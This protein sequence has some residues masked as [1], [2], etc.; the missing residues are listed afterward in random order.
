MKT[1]LSSA[2]Y[3]AYEDAFNVLNERLFDGKLPPT[4]LTLRAKKNT[5]GYAWSKRFIDHDQAY[6]DSQELIPD[7]DSLPGA[8]DEIAINPAT[9]SRSARDVLGTLLH[10][11][12]HVWQ[13]RFGKPSRNGYHNREWANKMLEV[14]LRPFN[15]KNP[16]QMTGQACSHTIEDGGIADLVFAEITQSFGSALVVELPSSAAKKKPVAVK[17]KYT[18]PACQCNV[19]GKPGLRIACLDCQCEMSCQDSEEG[20]E[21]TD[22]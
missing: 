2:N 22:Q 7:P 15:V 16:Q 18:C 13:F 1:N 11:M 10:E 17:S 14:G 19:W 9:A 5:H 8:Y 21:D 20:E 6:Q 4:V 3:K 12:C